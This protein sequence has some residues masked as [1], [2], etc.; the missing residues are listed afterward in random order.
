MEHPRNLGVSAVAGVITM[1]PGQTL[2]GVTDRV[3]LPKASDGE[4][5]ACTGNSPAGQ[6]PAFVAGVTDH[7]VI[8][9]GSDGETGALSSGNSP[10][11]QW[12]ASDADDGWEEEPEADG[13]PEGGIVIPRLDWDETRRD[14]FGSGSVSTQGRDFEGFAVPQQSPVRAGSQ[15]RKRKKEEKHRR[16]RK[17]NRKR[18]SSS[19]DSSADESPPKRGKHTGKQ[20]R[21]EPSAVMFDQFQAFWE[22]LQANQLPTASGT[23]DPLELTPTEGPS[24]SGRVGSHDSVQDSSVAGDADEAEQEG[25][26]SDDNEELVLGTEIPQDAFERAVKT[27]RRVLGFEEPQVTTVPSIRRSKLSLNTAQAPPKLTMPVDAEC[28]SRYESIAGASSW[29]AFHGKTRRSFQVED[30]DG[31]ELLHTPG[32]PP[33]ASDRMQTAGIVNNKGFYLDKTSAKWDLLLTDI[34]KASR[35]G[36]KYASTLLLIAEVISKSFMEA[37]SGGVS[38]KDTSAVVALLGPLSRLTFDQFSRASVRTTRARRA[39]ALDALNW[40]SPSTKVL[41]ENLP[42]TGKDL[43]NGKFEETLQAEAS[44]L[45]SMR[46]AGLQLSKVNRGTNKTA[47]FRPS[48]PRGKGQFRSDTRPNQNQYQKPGSYRGSGG[49]GTSRPN[50]RGGRGRS[51]G[52]TR[53]YYP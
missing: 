29:K 49:R 38:R 34:D 53:P 8:P 17:H 22:Q 42:L 7:T 19:S 1:E 13:E 25:S 41:F 48:F 26:E 15:T 30:A 3:V 5:G 16:R 35:E 21:V 27:L 11:G 20:T 36:M 28:Y 33:Q 23:T 4:T 39:M 37:D 45:N 50:R 12:P 32:L 6:G 18:Y 31:A 44:R 43:F 51:R 9:K 40:P 47:R 10:A 2:A 14:I 52:S 24:G 46:E